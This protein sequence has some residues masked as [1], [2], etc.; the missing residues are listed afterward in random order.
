ML[1]RGAHAPDACNEATEPASCCVILAATRSGRPLPARLL[2]C[3]DGGDAK[4]G[5]EK[6]GCMLHAAGLHAAGGGQC[7]H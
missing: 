1:E 5:T 3:G 6:G 2:S 7:L 4:G